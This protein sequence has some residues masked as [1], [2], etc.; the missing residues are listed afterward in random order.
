MFST[1]CFRPSH[2]CVCRNPLWYLVLLSVLGRPWPATPSL[3]SFPSS[4]LSSS[5][6]HGRLPC[7][8][9]P[10]TVPACLLEPIIVPHR[11]RNMHHWVYVMEISP[12]SSPYY[13][14]ILNRAASRSSHSMTHATSKSLKHFTI[15]VQP[16]RPVPLPKP[17]WLPTSRTYVSTSRTYVK[18]LMTYR[19]RLK[20]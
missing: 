7:R 16:S 10:R 3:P 17:H 19:V 12:S 14:N 11:D 18:L 13:I 5:G 20:G 2:A 8:R 1:T 4:F 6:D 9:P 15:S